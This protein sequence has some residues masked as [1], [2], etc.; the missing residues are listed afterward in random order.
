MDYYIP[1]SFLLATVV[2]LMTPGPV[3][4][5]VTHN[6]LRNGATAG[7]L[8]AASAEFGKVCL[9]GITFAGLTISGE[10]QPELFRWLS[11][12]AALYLVWRAANTL[13]CR[14]L[15]RQKRLIAGS[16]RPI[17]DGLSVGFGHPTA[18]AFFAAFLPEFMNAGDSTAGP[19]FR[20]AGSY[21]CTALIF[22]LALVLVISSVRFRGG[23]ARLGGLAEL[24]SVAVYLGI[25]AATTVEFLNATW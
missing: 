1:V 4:A 10:L 12:V 5:M 7:L 13:R 11:L 24:G 15:S 23:H 17:I 6:T 8:T 16:S 3:M 22:D 18:L 14:Y 9:I 19:M 25:A 2:F 21:L 20:L